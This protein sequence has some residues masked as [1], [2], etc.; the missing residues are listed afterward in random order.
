[1]LKLYNEGREQLNLAFRNSFQKLF[2]CPSLHTIPLDAL[3]VEGAIV[4]VVVKVHFH[5]TTVPFSPSTS[6]SANTRGLVGA[7]VG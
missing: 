4:D 5:S 1:M 2:D 3:I 6:H 7:R